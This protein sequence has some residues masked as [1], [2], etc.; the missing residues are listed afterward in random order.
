MKDKIL[1]ALFSLEPE[2]RQLLLC[3]AIRAPAL[4][5]VN[6]AEELGYIVRARD[7]EA[8]VP[9]RGQLYYLGTDSVPSEGV[10]E[11]Y[12][13]L[14]Y[15][16]LQPRPELIR[17][18]DDPSVAH[19]LNMPAKPG[20]WYEPRPQIVLLSLFGEDDPAVVRE[21]SVLDEDE[22]AAWV[23]D[24]LPHLTRLLLG[25]QVYRYN[26]ITA[27]EEERAQQEKR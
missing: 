26:V 20:L 16:E 1:S 10:F 24:H 2:D 22:K 3:D 5:A 6:G 11:R 7:D 9:I 17:L 19:I 13:A 8:W 14:V 4:R 23:V 18:G 15:Y 21:I 12:Y 27:R 25:H